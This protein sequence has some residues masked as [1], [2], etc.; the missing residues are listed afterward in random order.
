MTDEAKIMPQ[1]LE[2][3][4]NGCSP[5]SVIVEIH[6][7]SSQMINCYPEVKSRDPIC[8]HFPGNSPVGANLLERP[9]RLTADITSGS[10][11]HFV[12]EFP[13]CR[14]VLFYASMHS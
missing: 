5:I 1:K 4:L 13:S 10:A 7:R 12:I 11:K 14:S 3:N 2:K 9:T 6:I 8:L